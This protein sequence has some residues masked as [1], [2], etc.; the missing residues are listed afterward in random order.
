MHGPF[1]ETPCA[2]LSHLRL[3][4]VLVREFPVSGWNSNAIFP[5]LRCRESA[6]KPLKYCLESGP[7][8]GLEPQKIEN[9]LFLAENRNIFSVTGETG[10]QKTACTAIFLVSGEQHDAAVDAGRIKASLEPSC[11]VRAANEFDFDAVFLQRTAMLQP[12]IVDGI[13]NGLFGDASGS[14]INE[15]YQASPSP[16]PSSRP[17]SARIIVL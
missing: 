7:K 11:L 17:G 14:Q 6:P 8:A 16:M 10:S 12:V 9:S 4:A 15:L 2:F 5:V 3:I 13:Q 1:H